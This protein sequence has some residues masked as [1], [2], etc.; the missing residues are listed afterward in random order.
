[1]KLISALVKNFVRHKDTDLAAG[2][3]YYA[4]LAIFPAALALASLLAV[5]GEADQ[6]LDAVL[7]VLRPL[8]SAATLDDIEP[9]LRAL[10]RADGASW[11]L[12]AGALGALWSASAYVGAFA[13]ANNTIREVE[14]TRPFWKLRPL[15]L[16]ITLV[17]VVLNAAALLI[18]VATGDIA[19]S[20][21]D[22]IGLGRT[23][24]DTW[25][26]AK[27]PGLAI[28]VIIVVALLIH[29][30]PN[31]RTGIRLLSAGAFVAILVWV[32]ASAG[33]AYYVVNFSSYNK[34]YG[35]VAGVII[36]LVWLWLTNAALL[37]GAEI[38]AERERR[39]VAAAADEEQI[40][41]PPV[42][43][44]PVAEPVE[45]T[46]YGPMPQPVPDED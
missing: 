30:T 22:R 26:V 16:V 21:G 12:L 39:R 4:V 8:V 1:M 10:T 34:T 41:P 28:V 18:I 3:T 27:W 38:D 25:D 29:A 11:T 15:M 32:A 7:D 9:T 24:V 42:D 2:L 33:F 44:R 19:R 20:L 37:F 6:S 31:A 14:E 13:R 45:T 46:V 36:A 43:R 17:V 5:V 40:A 23:F 35:S